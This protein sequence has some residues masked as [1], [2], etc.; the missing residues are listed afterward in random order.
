[1]RTKV[2]E[3]LVDSMLKWAQE[4]TGGG[5]QDQMMMDQQ[6]QMPPQPPP[7]PMEQQPT[8]ADVNQAIATNPVSGLVGQAMAQQPPMNLPKLQE[9]M[10]QKLERDLTQSLQG[11]IPDPMEAEAKRLNRMAEVISAQTAVMQAQQQQKDV[12]S[13]ILQSAQAP[14][15]QAMDQT[16]TSM[17][18]A[19]GPQ[20]MGQSAA[21]DPGALQAMGLPADG[22]VPESEAVNQMPMPSQANQLPIPDALSLPD[23]G[24][25]SQMNMPEEGG[26]MQ[27]MSMGGMAPSGDLPPELQQM[28]LQRLMSQGVGR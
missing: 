6:Q 1:M 16:D 24:G 22:E 27:D 5:Q 20:I 23:Q 26:L 9:L 18:T 12:K 8:P 13:Q 3:S 15:Q 7:P 17:M 2:R 25:M 19:D 28:L 14:M 21:T 4:Q 11:S 10:A